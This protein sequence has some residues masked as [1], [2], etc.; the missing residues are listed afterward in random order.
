[1]IS[2]SAIILFF[3]LLVIGAP[4][5][6]SLGLSAGSVIW[7][8]EMPVQVVA[9]RMVNAVDSVPLLAVPL[10]IFSANIFNAIGL[11]DRIFDFTRLIVGRIRGGLAQ[12]CI[13]A[14]LVFSGISGAALADIGGL[15]NIQMRLLKQQGYSEEFGA[16]VTVAGATIGPI[17]PPSIPLIIFAATAEIS[18]VRLL[19]AGIVPALLITFL[20]M[21][22][23][24]WMAR[25]YDL[26]R[27]NHNFE[28][29]ERRAIV[30]DAWPAL[31]APIILVGGLMSG[32]FGPTEVAA[33]TVAYGLFLGLVVYR[34]LTWKSLI[35]AARDS[36]R[37][38]AMIL[39]VVATAAVFAWILTIE[40]VPVVISGALLKLSS[41]PIVILLLVNVLLLGVGMILESI[42][43]ILILTPI[44]VPAL[45]KIGVDP[46][47]FGV[48]MVLNLMIGLLTPQV[49]MSLYMMSAVSKVS[50]ERVF[51]GT[52]PFF[53]PLVL[54]LLAVT[55]IPELSLS[56]PGY[57]FG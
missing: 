34:S 45:M 40:Q 30:I 15:G 2:L 5:A 3:A 27:D 23:V 20:L 37:A 44:L 17:F 31:L 43:A 47:H 33:V 49:G 28:K 35:S 7:L 4:L 54:A 46:L 26:P 42:A 52:L 21:G 53:I 1:M 32:Y 11:T 24:A 19:I 10:F 6:V 48:I 14:A 16:G 41:N 29:G 56:L 25:R 22:M 38:T 12:V 36:V 55:L 51:R 8:A 50:V 9:Q 13:L 39:F 57:I 18:S